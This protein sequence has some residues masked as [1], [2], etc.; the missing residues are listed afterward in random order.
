MKCIVIEPS[1]TVREADLEDY[2]ALNEAVGGYIE[3][4][5]LG[6]GKARQDAFVNEDGKSLNLLWNAK[7]T[8]LCRA[9]GTGLDPQDG[10]VGNMVICGPA[11]GEGNSTDVDPV[12]AQK[13][14]STK[15]VYEG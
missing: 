3:L 15:W 5:H 10:I 14:L 13:L 9:M 7:A 2:D 8:G 4:L 11:D 1:G 12:F 6:H